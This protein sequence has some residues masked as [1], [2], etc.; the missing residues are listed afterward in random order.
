MVGVVSEDVFTF[1][2]IFNEEKLLS[3]FN[4]VKLFEKMLLFVFE[5]IKLKLFTPC[6]STNKL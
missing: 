3:S 2:N 5:I 6:S 1:V 4:K